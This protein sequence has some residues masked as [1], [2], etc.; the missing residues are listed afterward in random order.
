MKSNFLKGAISLKRLFSKKNSEK[1][2]VTIEA[3]IALTTFLFAFMMIF[4]IISVCRAQAKMQ[5]ALN[6]T[7]QEISQY[8]YIYGMSGLDE[9]LADFQTEAN[10]TKSDVNGLVGG[11]IEVFEGIQSLG[12]DARTVDITNVDTV[13]SSWENISADLKETQSDFTAVKQQIE[14]MAKDPQ[15]LL[16]GMAKL[17]GSETLE[18][19]KS[20]VI[21]EPVTR[22]LIQKHLKRTE[23]D[24]ADAFCKSVGIVPGSYFGT[25]S[26]F[27][28][29]DFSNSTLFPYGSA[30]ITLIATYKVKLLQLL[31]IDVD[32]TITQSATTRGWL[33]GDKTT[34]TATNIVESLKTDEDI[35]SSMWN[36]QSVNERNKAIRTLELNKLKSQGYVGVS[37]ETYIQ[38]YDEASN[39]FALIAMCNPIYGVDSVEKIDKTS[40]ENDIKRIAAQINSASDN[41][42]AITV[43]VKDEKGNMTT[44]QIDCSKSTINKKVVLIVPEDAGVKEYVQTVINECG[45]SGMFSVEAGY[46]TGYKLPEETN[47]EGGQ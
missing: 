46:G 22:A 16:F 1:G 2:S 39:T 15:K 13:L 23:N 47:G 26:F 24:T 37:G 42:Q 28:G 9:T 11:T 45:Y 40:V 32:F 21:A 38:A 12:E 43:K 41:R 44:K 25:T 17:I 35:N 3:T 31:P 7:A 36:S 10:N 33:H 27:N 8:S 20:R 6:N 18:V 14:E 34:N 4:S 5:V 29:I 30:E 19:A